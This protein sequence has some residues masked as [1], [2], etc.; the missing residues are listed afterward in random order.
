MVTQDFLTMVSCLVLTAAKQGFKPVL[1]TAGN[2]VVIVEDSEGKFDT[3]FDKDKWEFTH[4]K[5][6]GE[7]ACMS[8]EIGVLLGNGRSPTVSSFE[9]AVKFASEHL[10]PKN[11]TLTF[12]PQLQATN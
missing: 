3:Y 4:L 7:G 12:C 6:S 11:P 5:T 1:R 2:G 9:E 8:E 10:R